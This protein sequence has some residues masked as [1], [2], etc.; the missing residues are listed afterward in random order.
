MKGVYTHVTERDTKH[1]RGPEGGEEVKLE[2]RK[3]AR[4]VSYHVVVAVSVADLEARVALKLSEGWQP[5]GGLSAVIVP[6]GIRYLQA[7]IRY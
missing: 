6:V 2:E 5:V 3:A 1:L 4:E 7:M